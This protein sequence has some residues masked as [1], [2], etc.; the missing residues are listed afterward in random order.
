VRERATAAKQRVDESSPTLFEETLELLPGPL[1]AAIEFR[2]GASCDV[3]ATNIPIPLQGKLGE[4]PV[5]MMF[6]VAPS[7]G[8]AV[9]FSLTTYG[10][11]L[12]LAGNADCGIVPN[13]IDA[14]VEATLIEVFGDRFEGFGDIV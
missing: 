11:H 12:Y 9:S 6:M 10:E 8:Q 7:I 5:E 2:Q 1:R 3:L 14:S 13:P 4:V